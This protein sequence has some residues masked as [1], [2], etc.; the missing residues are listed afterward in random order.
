[1]KTWLRILGGLFV[2]MILLIVG[3]FIIGHKEG[4]QDYRDEV[5]EIFQAKPQ[6][7]THAG[8]RLSA[9]ET[10]PP[11]APRL[12]LIH[13]SPGNSL[14]WESF[15]NA[16]RLNDR[17]RLMIIDRPGFGASDI[18][19]HSLG[20]QSKAM[21]SLVTAF[22]SPCTVVGHSYGGAL[23]IQVAAHYPSHIQKVISI[24][25][26]VSPKRQ[27][28]R[29]YNRWAQY[30]PIR[31]F[32]PQNWRYS[33]NEMLSL[34]DDLMLLFDTLPT[35]MPPIVFLQGEEDVLVPAAS[36]FDVL[37]KVDNASIHFRTH[38]N[39]FLIWTNIAWVYSIMLEK[40]KTPSVN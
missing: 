2:P 19:E 23:A 3:F 31:S 32:L 8:G 11:T 14:A 21:Q 28:P 22:C 7:F 38:T 18:V 34:A 4:N 39:H 15:V 30:F 12:L 6:F 1:M 5:A 27:A 29:W 37:S 17:F 24:A 26:T 40:N 36:P 35:A 33:N 25:G 9:Y 10:G 20:A 16:T 13:G